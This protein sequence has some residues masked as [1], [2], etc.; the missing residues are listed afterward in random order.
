MDAYLCKPVQ[1]PLSA[2]VTLPGSKSITNRAMIL[3]ALGE[4]HSLL[5]N[6]LLAED[7][8]LMI[9]ALRALGV[10]VTVDER[11]NVAEVTGCRGFIPE[12][13]ASLFCVRYD[14]ALLH[15]VVRTGEW[16]VRS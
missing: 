6:V 7:T 14:D 1:D 16:E 15:G 11:A 3:A 12:E 13:E 4:G 5:R 8:W 9:E 2:V 10:A